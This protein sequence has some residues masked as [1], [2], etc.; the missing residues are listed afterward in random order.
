MI[1][2]V[3]ARKITSTSS[4]IGI[5]TTKYIRALKKTG[6]I[7][8]FLFTDIRNSLLMKLAEETKSQIIEY[9]E[10]LSNSLRIPKYFDWIFEKLKRNKVHIFW[11]PNNIFWTKKRERISDTAKIFVTIHDVIP[12]TSP[13]YYSFIYSIY[14]K[15]A[16]K[17]TLRSVDKIITVSRNT[18]T[19]LINYF[20]SD[21]IPEISVIP[22]IVELPKSIKKEK[23]IIPNNNYFIFIGNVEKRK[24]LEYLLPAFNNYKQK[25]GKN[26]LV[27]VGNLERVKSSSKM[28]KR[29]SKLLK[30]SL[31]VTGYLSEDQK[32]TLLT[33]PK[34][35]G[36]IQPSIDEGFGIPPVEA[37]LVG[38]PVIASSIPV[39]HEILGNSVHYFNIKENK[40]SVISNLENALFSYKGINKNHIKKMQEKYS[41]Q[42]CVKKLVSY[43]EG[44]HI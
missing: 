33:D 13:Q 9:G 1:I 31:I 41:A 6:N 18:K 7:E 12:L 2:A 19:Q 43:F 23:D 22:N 30:K 35:V 21:E 3:D 11:E 25:G 15:I 20:N 16:L 36:L 37:L 39:F 29:Y 28:I 26:N 8:F 27:I 38:K 17:K 10:D 44:H 14:F 4:G 32:W 34:C 24:G 5:Y 42:I 40:H